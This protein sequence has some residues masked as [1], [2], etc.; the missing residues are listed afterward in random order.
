LARPSSQPQRIEPSGATA[1]PVNPGFTASAP[2]ARIG[3]EKVRPPSVEVATKY[4]TSGPPLIASTQP[5]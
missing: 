4:A 1:M 5:R 2:C 3:S